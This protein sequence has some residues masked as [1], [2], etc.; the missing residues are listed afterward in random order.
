[1]AKQFR[2][3]PVAVLL[4]FSAF[5]QAFQVDV[6]VPTDKYIVPVK[7]LMAEWYPKINTILYGAQFPLPYP[8]IH[9][10]FEPTIFSGTGPDRVVVPAYALDNT[11]HINEDYLTRIPDDYHAMLIHEL[12]H[13]NQHHKDPGDAKWL[14]EGI[15]DYI[16]HKYYERDIVPRLNLDA[17]GNLKGVERD[18]NKHPFQQDGYR[19]G[20]TVTSA[21]LYWLELAK[22]KDIVA[23]VNLALHDG[24]Y[25]DAIFQRRCRAPLDTL[26]HEF[27]VQSTPH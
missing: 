5:G 25:S 22:D 13:I 11:I 15:A 7:A 24:N 10:L 8:T 6:E 4:A 23:T 16:R 14:I 1:V 21:F 12:T 9:I 17:S 18:R 20:Y 26:W 2:I 3:L 19:D 27:I